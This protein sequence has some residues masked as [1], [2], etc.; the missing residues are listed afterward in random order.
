M[1]VSA[2]GGVKSVQRG[3]WAMSTTAANITI[4][5]VNIEKSELALLGRLGTSTS[6]ADHS[7]RL[8]FVDASTL[9]IKRGAGTTSINTSWQLVEYW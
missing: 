2:Q 1:G 6:V 7:M 9:E 8:T 5:T 4:N 3:T